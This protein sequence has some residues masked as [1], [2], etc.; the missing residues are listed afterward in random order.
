MPVS[1]CGESEFVEFKILAENIFEKLRKNE[2]SYLRT[3]KRLFW[4]FYEG[5]D[6]V[7]HEY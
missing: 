4:H 5:T 1:Q 7:F 6:P 2:K 3:K